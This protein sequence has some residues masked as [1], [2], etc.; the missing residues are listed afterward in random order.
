MSKRA[1][2]ST[3]ETLEREHS[4]AHHIPL[5][6]ALRAMRAAGDPDADATSAGAHLRPDA[7]P[8]PV[9]LPIAGE[10][11]MLVDV[12]PGRGIGIDAARLGDR[13][14]R[15]ARLAFADEHDLEPADVDDVLADA[16]GADQDDE[17]EDE[18]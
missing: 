14:Q 8:P 15:Q 4:D 1:I 2:E 5:D 10:A 16:I 18:D 3:V 17:Q 9:L 12:V 6:D 7:V 13:E 11:F